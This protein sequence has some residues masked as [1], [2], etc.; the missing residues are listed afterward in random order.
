MVWCTLITFSVKNMNSFHANVHAFRHRGSL[1]E[2]LG[3]EMPPIIGT[4]CL[5][6]HAREFLR[7]GHDRHKT[8]RAI[9]YLTYVTL[10]EVSFFH[11]IF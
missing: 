4:T 7:M 6:D 3:D 11:N 8:P 2:S 9:A 1:V 10:Q 5:I